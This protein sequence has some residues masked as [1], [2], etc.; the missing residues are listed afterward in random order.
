M[1]S[2]LLTPTL[3]LTLTLTQAIRDGVI[4]ASLDH[5]AGVLLSREATDLYS[6]LEPQAAFHKRITF[7]LNIHN[8]HP[9]S[10]RALVL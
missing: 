2:G 7:C 8:K 3:A 9:K 1:S 5:E 4:E 6:T 10:V